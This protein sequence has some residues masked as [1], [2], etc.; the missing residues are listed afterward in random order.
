MN[1]KK[2]LEIIRNNYSNVDS[3]IPKGYVFCYDESGNLLFHMHNMIVKSGRKKIFEALTGGDSL[4]LGS[5][6]A[7]L[8]N[9]TKLVTADDIISDNLNENSL[10][11][12]TVEITPKSSGSGTLSGAD[13]DKLLYRFV[14]EFTHAEGDGLE[15]IST[16]GL[17]LIEGS[18]V[19]ATKTLFS[20]VVFPKYAS[21]SNKLT[22]T[23]YLYF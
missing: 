15:F 17:V 20:R 3:C 16:L 9:S 18:G 4:D 1:S 8:G 12:N 21:A 23:Y 22:F 13:N 14:I 19:S 7:I 10:G 6:K 11:A 5:L 2:E